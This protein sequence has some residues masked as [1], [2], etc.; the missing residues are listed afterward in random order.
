MKTTIA[1]SRAYSEKKIRALLIT[2]VAAALVVLGVWGLLQNRKAAR[3]QAQLQ[4]TCESALYDLS[5]YL[6]QMDVAFQKSAYVSTPYGLELLSAEIYQAGGYAKSCIAQLPV[7]LATLEHTEQYLAQATEYMLLLGRRAAQGYELTAADQKTVQALAENAQKLAVQVSAIRDEMNDSGAWLTDNEAIL[8]GGDSSHS[9]FYSSLTGLED[10]MTGYT[11]PTYEGEYSD[12]QYHLTSALL[13]EAEEITAQRAKEIAA[14]CLDVSVSELQESGEEAGGIEALRFSAASG[15]VSVSKRGG[16]PVMLLKTRSVTSESVMSEEGAQK[17]A[18]AFLVSFGFSDLLFDRAVTADGVSM[19][20]YV[21]VQDGVRV[22]SDTVQVA[23]AMDDGEI[24]GLDT[25]QYLLHYR[26][27]EFKTPRHTAADAVKLLAPALT[28][29]EARL[30]TF[31]KAGN[32]S[33][34]YWELTCKGKNDETVVVYFSDEQ[35]QEKLIRLPS[36]E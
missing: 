2:F 1:F 35:L 30:T 26:R 12:S 33:E 3:Y 32:G 16:Y 15:E 4:Y 22:Y 19:L 25:S 14:R 36:Q 18:E 7:G 11:P 5:D 21:R 34:L 17:K 13:G 10:A 20:R 29:T 9:S 23:V 6:A 24:L 8:F 31:P 27:Y 28:L